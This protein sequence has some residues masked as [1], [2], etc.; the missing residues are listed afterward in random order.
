M[1]KATS[2]RSSSTSSTSSAAFAELDGETGGL[3]TAGRH[4]A[5]GR[6]ART[7]LCGRA[8]HLGG[9]LGHGVRDRVTRLGRRAARGRS[10]PAR[11]RRGRA[12]GPSRGNLIDPH[13]QG[14]RRHA[15]SSTHRPHC[16]RT[17]VV[18]GTAT[19]V[20]GGVEPPPDSE[21]R[22]AGAGR[23]AAPAARGRLCGRGRA[24]TG[25]WDDAGSDR[26]AQA[27]RRS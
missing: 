17:A 6:A 12:R 13:T 9:R 16:R 10:Y 1:P 27:A 19:V 4:R 11:A 14:D 20:A 18:A 25:R 8:A 21:V 7:E 22:R 23:G 15:S 24:R 3:I 26:T 2:S 5:C